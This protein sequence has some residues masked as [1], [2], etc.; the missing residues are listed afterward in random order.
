MSGGTRCIY[1]CSIE[2]HERER[3]RGMREGERDTGD[4]R[5]RERERD[6]A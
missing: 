2:I 1:L 3:E 5:G 6:E 4:E